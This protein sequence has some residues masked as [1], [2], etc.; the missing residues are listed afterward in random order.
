MSFHDD[1]IRAIREKR[2]VTVT[3]RTDDK[4]TVR[5]TCV[6]LDYGPSGLPRDGVDR[7]HFR[8]LSSPTGEHPL[9]ILP[10]QLLDIRVLD[11]TFEPGEHVHG[12]IQWSVPRDWGKFS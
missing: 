5:R 8:D 3:A 9:M 2:L 1:F 4:G 10:S 11:E 7:Y 12:K 6:P